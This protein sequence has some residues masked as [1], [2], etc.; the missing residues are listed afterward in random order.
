MADGFE[1]VPV[2]VAAQRLGIKG[3]PGAGSG[4]EGHPAGHTDKC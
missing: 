4:E 1:G 3:A 2:A